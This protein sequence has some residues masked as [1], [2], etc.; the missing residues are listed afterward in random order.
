MWWRIVR[1]ASGW[2]VQLAPA[3]ANLCS[4]L[5]A[6]AFGLG[7]VEVLAVAV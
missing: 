5:A 3:G 4:S 6:G 1:A 7:V 2:P